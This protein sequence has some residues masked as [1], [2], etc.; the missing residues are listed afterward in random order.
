NVKNTYDDEHTKNFVDKLKEN[1]ENK[2]TPSVD[3]VNNVDKYL[4]KGNY[5]K[6]FTFDRTLSNGKNYAFE[7][8]PKQYKENCDCAKNFEEVDQCPVDEHECNK[9][10]KYPCRKNHFNRNRIEWNNY[11]VKNNSN[12]NKA[13]M[14]PPRR[15]HICFSSIS[16]YSGR[17]KNKTDFKEFI[18][19]AA[20]N[21]AKRL[22]NIYNNNQTKALE[23][24]KYSFADIGNIVK[25]N[26]MLNDG[27]SDK[28]K[29]IFDK[30][31]N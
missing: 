20:Y 9:Y 14:V 12:I 24:M 17:I 6:K 13:V 23:A 27:I 15:K 1:C 3:S 18:L 8:A 30:K 31:I 16:T 28:I 22:W 10:V 5:C 2:Q 29:D 26:D 11:F 4:D 21:E 25:G 7:E 19:Y